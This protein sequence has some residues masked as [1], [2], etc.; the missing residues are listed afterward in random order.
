MEKHYIENI[1][2]I[3]AQYK[4]LGEKAMA[5]VEEKRLFW[6]FNNE[7]NS[8]AIIVQH[9]SGNMI[10]R[11]TNFYEEDG[12][13]SWRNRDREFETILSTRAEVMEAWNNGWNVFLK[14]IDTLEPADLH[15]TVYIRNEAHTVVQ[16]IQRQLA[17]YSYHIGQ[18]VFLSKMIAQD[19][20][21]SLSIPKNQSD[22]FNRMMT[23]K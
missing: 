13:K 10:S 16:A 20:W 6:V 7:S 17:H 15:K 18:I 23:G 9:V 3:F 12:E 22:D 5:Q 4:A 1:Q 19:N 14:V 11:F 2:Q 21:N 8:I